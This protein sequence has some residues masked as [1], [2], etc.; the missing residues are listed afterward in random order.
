MINR[1]SKEFKPK[2]KCLNN[3][4]FLR[5]ESI[6][7]LHIYVIYFCMGMFIKIKRERNI[8]MDPY[9]VFYDFVIS[10]L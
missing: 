3:C 6:H 2:K 9:C 8:C 1:L 10:C 5:R 4:R 7:M